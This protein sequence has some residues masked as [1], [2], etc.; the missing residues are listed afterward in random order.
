MEF[1]PSVEVWLDRADQQRARQHRD[2][3]GQLADRFAVEIDQGLDTSE[4]NRKR[5][6][7]AGPHLGMVDMGAA[8][9]L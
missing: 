7:A 8:V 2:L 1:W 6:A 3:E 9:E 4:S 5:R